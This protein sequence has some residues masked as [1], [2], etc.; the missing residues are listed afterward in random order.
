MPKEMSEAGGEAF[1]Q[2]GIPSPYS[3]LCMTH[4]ESIAESRCL[5][6][7]FLCLVGMQTCITGCMFESERINHLIETVMGNNSP[8]IRALSVVKPGGSDVDQDNAPR[9]TE[10]PSV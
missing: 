10:V 5:C 1:E 3:L 8:G 9:H 4:R 6:H 7:G 2:V